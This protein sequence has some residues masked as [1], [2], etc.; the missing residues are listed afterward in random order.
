MAYERGNVYSRL[1]GSNGRDIITKFR[2]SERASF[3]QEVHRAGWSA[4]Q[5]YWRGADPTISDDHRRDALRQLWQHLRRANRV[6][7]VMR[8]GIDE[9]GCEKLAASVYCFLSGGSVEIACTRD[10]VILDGYAAE[11]CIAAAAIK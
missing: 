3:S 5:G 8:M 9:A 4:P 2:V 10:D 1:C 6:Q 7:I 11:N